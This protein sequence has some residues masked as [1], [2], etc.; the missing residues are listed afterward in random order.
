M[1][2]GLLGFLFQGAAESVVNLAAQAG[3]NDTTGVKKGKK[4]SIAG[5][6]RPCAAAAKREAMRQKWQGGK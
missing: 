5:G 1:A 4:G 2:K 6:C 3:S